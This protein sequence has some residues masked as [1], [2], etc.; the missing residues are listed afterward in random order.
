[1]P[2]AFVPTISLRWRSW[3]CPSMD[4]RT[5]LFHEADHFHDIAVPIELFV[6][7]EGAAYLMENQVMESLFSFRLEIGK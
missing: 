7:F 4:L 6:K 2:T 5:Q 3:A 1:M